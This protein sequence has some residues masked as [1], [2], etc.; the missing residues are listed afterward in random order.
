MIY[1]T[2]G[3]LPLTQRIQADYGQTRELETDAPEPRGKAVQTLTFCDSDHA[4]DKVTRRSRTGILLYVNRALVNWFSKKQNLVETS[5]F[6][7]EFMALKTALEMVIGLR[8][9]L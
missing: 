8:Y 5:T 1:L 9:K 4:G 3:E 2:R 6:G 7:S